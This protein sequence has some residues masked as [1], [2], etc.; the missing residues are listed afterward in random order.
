METTLTEPVAA[1]LAS[2]AADLAADP[3]RRVDDPSWLGL[4]RTRSCHLPPQLLEVLR[5]FRH[6]PGADAALLVHGLPVPDDIGA[7]PA[8]AGS[9]QE[10][11]TSPAALLALVC[12]QL[13]ELVAYRPEKSGA[14][15]QDVVPV[16]GQEAEQSN[17]GSTLLHMHTENAFHP[18]RPDYV[19]LLCLRADPAD[20]A[21]LTVAS[22]RNALP[23]LSAEARAVLATTAYVTE[24]PPSFG[25]DCGVAADHAVLVGDL[26]DPDLLVDFASTRPK[27]AAATAAMAE[28]NAALRTVARTLKLHAGDVAIVDNRLAVH[29]RTSFRPRYDGRDRWLQ[30]SFVHL[31]HRRSRVMRRDGG[32]VLD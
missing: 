18:Y 27:D 11:V 32:F 20:E 15:V 21:A 14:L 7:T 19:A 30:R 9:V 8:V 13:G 29:G 25:A 17:V 10:H 26:A 31:N 1:A 5:E 2:C 6:E 4:A 24:A 23:L 16:P 22:V 3:T 28:L 12:Q